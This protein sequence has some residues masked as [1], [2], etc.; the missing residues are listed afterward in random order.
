MPK[1]AIY[2]IWTREWVVDAHNLN[3]AHNMVNPSSTNREDL[4]FSN[5]HIIPF[6]VPKDRCVS[7]GEVKKVCCNTG[8]VD[9]PDGSTTHTD[10]VCRKCCEYHNNYVK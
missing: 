7:C 2:E 4:A 6:D 1:F 5:C 3:A 10:P 9:N 8:Y